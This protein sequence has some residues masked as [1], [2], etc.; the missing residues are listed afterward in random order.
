MQLRG[1]PRGTPR[2]DWAAVGGPIDGAISRGELPT[3]ATRSPSRSP[4]Y[5]RAGQAGA[6]CVL[7]RGSRHES[8]QRERAGAV[9]RSQGYTV[10]ARSRRSR[11]ASA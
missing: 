11:R 2:D 5:R 10:R 1:N 7:P 6:G 4:T 3:T 9:R 8:G